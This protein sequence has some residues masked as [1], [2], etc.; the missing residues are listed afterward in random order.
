MILYSYSR[1]IALLS[2]TFNIPFDKLYYHSNNPDVSEATT[3]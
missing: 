3:Y 1:L 2:F